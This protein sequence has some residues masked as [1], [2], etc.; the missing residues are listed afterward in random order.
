[1]DSLVISLI[2]LALACASGVYTAE[3]VNPY[4]C[5]AANPEL[6]SWLHKRLQSVQRVRFQRAISIAVLARVL[7]GNARLITDRNLVQDPLL[8]V[9]STYGDFVLELKK[10]LDSHILPDRAVIHL[11]SDDSPVHPSCT[12]DWLVSR[13][14]ISLN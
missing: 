5:S 14:S 2:V 8:P 6:V 4:A 3:D 13:P 9:S 11:F 7:E 1:M 12:G 10:V